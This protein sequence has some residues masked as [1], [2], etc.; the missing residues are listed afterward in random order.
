MNH[1]GTQNI[2]T[3][4]FNLRRFKSSDYMDMY[5]NWTADPECAKFSSWKPHKNLKVTKAYLNNIIKQY[6][7]DD[8][9]RWA[10]IDQN[11][12]EVI[13]SFI[14]YDI[15]N[16]KQSCIVGYTVARKLWGQGIASEVLTEL[17]KYL[18]EQIGFKTIRAY[19][20]IKNIASGKVMIKAGMI[21]EKDKWMLNGPKF[22][23]KC[24]IYIYSTDD[25]EA[26]T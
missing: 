9:Y 24:C 26:I 16:K 6:K 18:T 17:I 19:H 12:G 20:Y 25:K 7:K 11:K 13:G 8:Y 1:I 4:R 21:Y 2:Q 14:V 22:I 15:N 5:N 3:E 23:S 10:I